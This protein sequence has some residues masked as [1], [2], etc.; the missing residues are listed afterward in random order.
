MADGPTNDE[1]VQV[2]LVTRLLAERDSLRNQRDRFHK[3]WNEAQSM[4]ASN[5]S[6]MEAY[7]TEAMGAE[8][9]VEALSEA[10][11]RINATYDRWKNDHATDW[12]DVASKMDY[13]ARHALAAALPERQEEK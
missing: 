10:L 8:A 13:A 5:L 6:M 7:R 4:A 1:I 11:R 3:L 2:R 9:R 12:Q